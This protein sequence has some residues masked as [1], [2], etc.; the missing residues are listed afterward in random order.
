MW[1]GGVFG[2]VLQFDLFQSRGISAPEFRGC[3]N[4]LGFWKFCFRKRHCVKNMGN[5]SF[6][7]LQHTIDGNLFENLKRN[8]R[9]I[10]KTS[11]SWKR[12]NLQMDSVLSVFVK[13]FESLMVSKT[14][15]QNYPPEEIYVKNC[16]NIHRAIWKKTTFNPNQ[17]A[18]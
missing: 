8:T 2:N 1:L 3:L 6:Q 14:G 15:T 13:N 18:L 16:R 17:I 10:L 9:K 4:F 12:A 5:E 7:L 11:P